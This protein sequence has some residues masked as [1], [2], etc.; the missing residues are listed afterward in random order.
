MTNN[1]KPSNSTFSEN[2]T[3]FEIV[4]STNE[5]T[6]QQNKDL[7]GRLLSNDYNECSCFCPLHFAELG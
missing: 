1:S 2:K 6:K 7:V 4:N 5:E 3:I